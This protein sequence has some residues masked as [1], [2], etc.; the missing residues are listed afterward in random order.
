MAIIGAEDFELSLI[1]YDTFG[2]FLRSGT[3]SLGDCQSLTAIYANARG[4][5][6]EIMR[7]LTGGASFPEGPPADL[8]WDFQIRLKPTTT[9]F[10]DL[11]TSGFGE[12]VGDS[13]TFRFTGVRYVSKTWPHDPE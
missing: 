13:G 1:G 8:Y 6:R 9:G 10:Y 4:E 11:V 3:C 7:L 5:F 12:R 2:L